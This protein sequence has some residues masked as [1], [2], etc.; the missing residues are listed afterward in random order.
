MN[1]LWLA[2]GGGVAPK[3]LSTNVIRPPYKS[4]C[5]PMKLYGGPCPV[6][7]ENK[8]NKVSSSLTIVDMQQLFL[9]VCHHRQGRYVVKYVP[10]CW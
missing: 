8:V 10:I 5:P 4:P 9:R 2:Q 1:N 7:K 6:G 3:S